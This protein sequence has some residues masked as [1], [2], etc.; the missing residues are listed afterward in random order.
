M[1]KRG[2]PQTVNQTSNLS[3]RSLQNVGAFLYL[4]VGLVQ[5]ENNL[6]FFSFICTGE[7]SVVIHLTHLSNYF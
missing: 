7:P 5:Q 1:T 2:Q 6:T 4:M 3:V